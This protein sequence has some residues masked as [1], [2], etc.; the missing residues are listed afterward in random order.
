[1]LDEQGKPTRILVCGSRGWEDKDIIRTA[2]RQWT[3]RR[4]PTTVM[5]GNCRGADKIAD[6]VARELRLPIEPY[7][8]EWDRYGRAAGPMRN[9]L[10]LDQNPDMVLA[11]VRGDSPGT[12]DTCAE[13]RRRGIHVQAYRHP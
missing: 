5:H 12:R 7:D 2:L 4:N 10:M 9:R 13:A 3:N 6:E 8:A 1:M 11:F